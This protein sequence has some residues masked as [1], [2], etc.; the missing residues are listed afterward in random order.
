MVQR[1]TSNPVLSPNYELF[2]FLY[3]C[4]RFM[5]KKLISTAQHGGEQWWKAD[6]C[7]IP[8]TL[9]QLTIC[10]DSIQEVLTSLQGAGTQTFSVMMACHST[11]QSVS[12]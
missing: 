12:K 8:E 7:N 4:I 10:W 3:Q 9:K 11:D 1:Y 6:A 2:T 5:G